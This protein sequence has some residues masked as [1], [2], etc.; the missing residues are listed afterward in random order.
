MGIHD[1]VDKFDGWRI[2]VNGKELKHMLSGFQLRNN[3]FHGLVDK[4]GFGK[5]HFLRGKLELFL[6]ELF[7][8]Q[9]RVLSQKMVSFWFVFGFKEGWLWISFLI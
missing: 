1:T 5:R 4:N 3:G 7:E 2:A 9:I 6:N 8:L